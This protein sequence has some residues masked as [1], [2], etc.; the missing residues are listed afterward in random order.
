MLR[1]TTHRAIQSL[2][3]ALPALTLIV[4]NVTGEH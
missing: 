4:A 3:W 1:R 2:A